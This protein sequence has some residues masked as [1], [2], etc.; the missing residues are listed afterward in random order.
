MPDVDDRIADLQ[1]KLRAIE[2]KYE[3]LLETRSWRWTRPLRVIG[4][5]WRGQWG[6]IIDGAKPYVK[7][8]GRRLYLY[9]PL[10]A[11]IKLRILHIAYRNI[12]ALFEG[13]PHYEA[14]KQ[15]IARGNWSMLGS[16]LYTTEQVEAVL[17]SL[18]FDVT[19]APLVSIIM[20][21]YGNLRLT[22]RCI[23]SIAREKP[24]VPVEIIV[25]E[26]ASGDTDIDR[27]SRIHGIHFE[28]N[29]I[30]Y[31]FLRSCNR[32]TK[33]FARGEYL[34]FLNN[35]TEVTAGWLDAMLQ[36]FHNRPDCGIVGSKLLFPN[37]RL[38]EA[39]GIVW[40]DGSAWNFGRGDDANKGVYNYTREVDY[41]SGASLLIK[42]SLFR[43]LNGFDDMYWPA[44]C[45]DTDLAFRVREAGLK[46]Y[47][48]P[49]SIVIHYEGMSHGTDVTVGLKAYQVTNQ[50]KFQK[51]WQ[52]V[53]DV[54][55][56]ANGV[57]VFHAK[58]RSIGRPSIVVIDH[59]IPTPDKDAGSRSMMH[60]IRILADCGM[61]VKFWPHNGWYDQNYGPRLEQ[62]GVEILWGDGQEGGFARWVQNY[63]SYVDYFFLS[64]PDVAIHYI[65]SIRRHSKA[66]ILYY[67]HDV[68]HL[69]MAAERRTLGRGVGATRE[70]ARMTDLEREIWGAVEV[71]YYPSA[72]EVEYVERH[73]KA[74]AVRHYVRVLP[75][76]G[77]EDFPENPGENLGE[78]SGILFVAGFG[79]PPNR[80][81]ALWLV[82][83]VMPL[84]WAEHQDAQLYLVGSN[85]SQ[86]I[87]ALK[88]P[89][90][91]VT[92][93]VSDDELSVFYKNARVA[94]APLRFGAGVKGKVVEAMRYGV[95]V[96]T[97]SVGLQGLE[98]IGDAVRDSD[99]PE[100]LATDIV[101]LLRDDSHWR[102]VSAKVQ[103]FARTRFSLGALATVISA[104]VNCASTTG[105]VDT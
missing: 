58:D 50:R 17:G 36:V 90:V 93:H 82:R 11:S 13:I 96:V 28:K 84:V 75:V 52:H 51:K 77:F 18:R 66:K 72:S 19:E 79:H 97:T 74:S 3:R 32:A 89:R 73:L 38:Q 23:A 44:Y 47:Y 7:R 61:S 6:C 24:E 55:H 95:P 99:D 78:R 92:G 81:A 12:G 1:E 43:K 86:E 8:W 10:S 94:V 27:L 42:A 25:V 37:G 16:S 46:V 100:N 70:E 59:Y 85:P 39:G 53:L 62:M 9:V 60:I 80:D 14:W 68:H 65:K 87:T 49:M 40:R 2:L 15:S 21:T 76:F 22:L 103:D 63:G 54:S 102:T 56:F 29:P 69:R 57:D 104:D 105:R 91:C 88:S 98:G 35:D 5:L 34:Y 67:G 83:V 20:P 41:C 71:I 45:E 26:D 101:R 30:N 33:E 4:R 31:G 48:Q 64:R